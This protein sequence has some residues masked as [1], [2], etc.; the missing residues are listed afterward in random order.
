MLRAMPQPSYDSQNTDQGALLQKSLGYWNARKYFLYYQAVFQYVSVIANEA[1]SIIDVGSASAE[2]IKWMPWIPSRSLLD[3]RI[4]YHPNDGIHRIETDFFKFQPDN[5]YDVA[6][7]CQVLE[8]VEDPTAFCD[9]LKTICNRLLV[10]VPYKWRGN[11]PGHI[12][13]PVDEAKLRQ[14]MRIPPN[15]SQV[16][17]EPFREG[18]LIAYYDLEKGPGFRFDKLY[19]C[20]AIAERHK[21]MDLSSGIKE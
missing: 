1:Q 15:Y 17:H 19:V 3:Y 2:Y 12:H 21:H 16:I 6:L 18:R 5:T 10:T 7:C 20:N 13:D 8:H 11:A 4:A 9:K 14:W